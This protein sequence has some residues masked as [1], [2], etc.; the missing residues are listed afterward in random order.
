MSAICSDFTNLI[1]G[2][3]NIIHDTVWYTDCIS[4][5]ITDHTLVRSL[6]TCRITRIN[7]I[8]DDQNGKCE[9][10]QMKHPMVANGRKLSKTALREIVE[11]LYYFPFYACI[12]MFH[13]QLN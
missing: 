5:H 1:I 6:T 9:R 4:R 8:L 11:V 10:N 12:E 3:S 7:G 2:I 13:I